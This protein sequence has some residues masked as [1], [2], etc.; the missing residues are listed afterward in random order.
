MT[1]KQHPQITVV[2]YDKD[3]SENHWSGL[4]KD[5]IDQVIEIETGAGKSA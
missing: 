3:G 1:V 4:I 2:V 5:N